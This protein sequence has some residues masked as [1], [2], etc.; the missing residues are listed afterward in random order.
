MMVNI[1]EI[2]LDVQKSRKGERIPVGYNYPQDT[3]KKKQ[4][5]EVAHWS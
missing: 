3:P 2:Y 5:G 1:P 4:V